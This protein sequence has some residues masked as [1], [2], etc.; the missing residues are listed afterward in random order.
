MATSRS[1]PFPSPLA[2]VDAAA[3]PSW[4]MQQW[5]ESANASARLQLVWLEMLGNAMQQEAEFFKIM[6]I[7]TEK[8]AHGAMNQELLGDPTA[9]AAHYQ[10]VAG[11]IHEATMNRMHKV[12]ELSKDFR[13]CLW[14]E[15]C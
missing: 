9:M 1:T 6:A 2:D 5:M 7:S 14:E 12:T 15:I 4:W 13:E 3:L 11:E 8:L 10:E